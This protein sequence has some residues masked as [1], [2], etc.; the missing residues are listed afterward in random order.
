MPEV[1][2]NRSDRQSIQNVFM[3][4]SF[5]RNGAST[6]LATSEQFKNSNPTV[7]WRFEHLDGFQWSV[8][9]SDDMRCSGSQSGLSRVKGVRFL[10][11][12]AD[13]ACP[14]NFNGVFRL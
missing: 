14:I 11:R 13:I 12:F 10:Y 9:A 1:I 4:K 5:G 6:K 3:Y 7:E 8:G 2:Y